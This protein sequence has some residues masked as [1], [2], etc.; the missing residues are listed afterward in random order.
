MFVS[1]LG[2]FNFSDISEGPK[3][4]PI[5]LTFDIDVD[6]ILNVTAEYETTGNNN[7]IT[8]SNDT[9]QLLQKKIVRLIQETRDYKAKDK[10]FLEKARARN[11]L[12]DYFYKMEK[13]LKAVE[14]NNRMITDAIVKVKSLLDG[15]E[16]Q[17]EKDVFK[18]NLKG[19]WEYFLV[20]M[21]RLED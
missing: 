20:I 12:D 11:D 1:L 4:H 18:K 3:G 21:P 6:G 14:K 16:D 5:M 8:I 19:A 15:D 2:W 10:K 17:H 13:A 9:G 7:E